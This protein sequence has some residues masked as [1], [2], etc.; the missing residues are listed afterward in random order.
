MSDDTERRLTVLETTL[1]FIQKGIKSLDEKMVSHMEKTDIARAST[2]EKID[3]VIR[4]FD[5]VEKQGEELKRLSAIVSG[6]HDLFQQGKGAWK[7]AAAIG[8]IVGAV[9]AGLLALLAKI[10]GFIRIA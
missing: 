10:A 6:H 2:N 9:V 7:A 1:P 5:T 4:K 8:S 3:T